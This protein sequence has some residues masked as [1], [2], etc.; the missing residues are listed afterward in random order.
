MLQ[1]AAHGSMCAHVCV[2]GVLR[3]VWAQ[4]IDFCR[5]K[6]TAR[7]KSVAA[8]RR[9]LNKYCKKRELSVLKVLNLPHSLCVNLTSQVKADGL[10]P[11]GSALGDPGEKCSSP[12]TLSLDNIG[13]LLLPT[14][15]KVWVKMFQ[16]T[17]R[18]SE[19]FY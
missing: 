15:I 8:Q 1:R 7:I 14:F 2:W 16:A 6:R 11:T 13:A 10:S 5:T 3:A 18:A 4:G 19:N 9:L 12:V 17:R